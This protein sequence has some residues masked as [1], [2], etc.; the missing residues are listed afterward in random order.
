MKTIKF[1]SFL[2]MAF[3]A[4]SCSKDDDGVEA[5]LYN[6]NNLTGTYSITYY[7]TKKVE[8]VDVNGFDVTTTTLSTGDTFNITA[9]FDSNDILTFDGTFRIVEVKTQ[10]GQNTENPYI[11]VQNEEKMAYT[12][13]ANTSELTFADQTYKV[14]NFSRTG[15]KI[16]MEKTTVN[17][18][19][20]TT[21]YSENWTFS[22]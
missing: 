21:V 17:D 16:D 19:G 18:N 5:Y 11:V 13:N 9:T 1:L 3:V 2:V 4:F 12:V 8:T 15:F 6:K 7:Q 14:S 20:D 10:N 22:K